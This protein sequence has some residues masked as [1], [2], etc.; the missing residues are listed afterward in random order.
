ML[1]S[2][3][4]SR[5][6]R[7]AVTTSV[8]PRARAISAGRRS[9][10][11][12]HTVRAVSYPSSPGQISPPAKPVRNRSVV[13]RVSD[14]IMVPFVMLP[15]LAGA[16]AE[17]PRLRRDACGRRPLGHFPAGVPHP[18]GVNRRR[19]IRTPQPSHL[20]SAHLGPACGGRQAFDEAPGVS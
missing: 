1:I 10:A 8:V 14:V 18:R 3:A 16:L 15:L 6:N 19:T 12:F 11:A 7:T 20:L 4:H 2:M 9:I 13:A 17:R 5:A